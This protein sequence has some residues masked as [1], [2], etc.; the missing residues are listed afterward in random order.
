MLK[1]RLKRLR[2]E[3]SLTQS[4]LAGRLG[5][6][7]QAVAKWES[8]R[9]VPEPGLLLP[10]AKIFGVSADYLLGGTN[11]LEDNILPCGDFSLVP[12]AGIVKAGFGRDAFEDISGS[13]PAEVRNPG[14]Y[15]YLTVQGDSM[16]P[17]IRTGDLALVRRQNTLQN[18]ELGVMVLRG[19]EGTLKRFFME[20]GIVL[21]KSF[22]PSSPTLELKGEDISELFILGKVVETKTRW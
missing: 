5:I 15:F 9:S 7:Q 6:T 1:K 14:D 4:E 2:R 19:G 12:V 21:L 11:P 17:H 20:N 8:G 16:E 13:Y 22:N 18:G 10:L 3:H